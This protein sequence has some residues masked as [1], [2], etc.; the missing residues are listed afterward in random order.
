[1][2]D[3]SDGPIPVTVITGFLG[4]GKTT[5]LNRL[6]SAPDAKD[7]AVI[8]N[9]FGD[10][11]IDGALVER[12]DEELIELNSGCV[13]CV[14]RGD[15]IRTVRNLLRARPNLRG[16]FV[17]TTGLAHPGPVVQTFLVDQVIAGRCELNTVVTV[18]DCLS[19][20]ERLADCPETADQIAVANLVLLNKVAECSAARIAEAEARIAEINPF[21]A[22]LRT[23]RCEISVTEILHR[24]D[25]D[26]SNIVDELTRLPEQEPESGHGHDHH[27]HSHDTGIQSVSCEIAPPVDRDKV[28]G[29]IEDLLAS[30]GADILRV[31]G[32][33]HIESLPDPFVLHGVNMT[34]EGDF[35]DLPGSRA[36]GKSR[37]VFIGRHLD[38]AAL[39]AQFAACAA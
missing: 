18:T 12:T 1:M 15:L 6:L 17:E 20:A 37:I 29:W 7:C 16:I 4:A 27:G 31:K 10:I 28:E 33:L 11:G 9:E 21:A 5:L 36:D 30:R 25:F 22:I 35:A 8:V 24:R 19:L 14:L 23:D 39:Q 38:P 3:G 32:I 2:A 34:V 26:L 13:C